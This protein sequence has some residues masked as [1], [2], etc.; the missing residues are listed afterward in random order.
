MQTLTFLGMTRFMTRI[1]SLTLGLL[2]A[3]SALADVKLENIQARYGR[4]GPIRD[5]LKALPGDEVMFTFTIVGLQPDET[6]KLDGELA[7]KVTTSKGEVV[8]DQKGPLKQVMAF[9]G[10]T[11]PSNASLTFGMNTPA[12][13]YTVTVTVTD[14]TQ[15]K[16]ASFE[17]TVTCLKRG[18]GIIRHTLSYDPDGKSSASTTNQM[19]QQLF[20]KMTAVGFDRSK[21]IDLLMTLQM[22]DDAGKPLMS[23]PLAVPLGTDDPEKLQTDNVTFSGFFWLSRVGTF[24][25]KF[26]V[27]DKVTDKTVTWEV[28]LKVN[29]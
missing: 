5:S 15:K 10:P 2:F 12:D 14:N 22:F 13:D 11:V 23:K 4:S 21:K 16:S 1:L 3:T 9:G 29:E 20:Y 27:T 18:F 25:A 6:G 19:G 24:K 8:L 28:P 7:Q 26:V 17:R